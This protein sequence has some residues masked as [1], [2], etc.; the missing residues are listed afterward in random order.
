MTPV[1]RLRVYANRLFTV[2][3]VALIYGLLVSV[4]AQHVFPQ[5]AAANLDSLAFPWFQFGVSAL[6]SLIFLAVG[7]LVWFSDSNS[8]PARARPH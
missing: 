5:G 1:F 2:L 3:L 4:K 6:V 7:A 8:A